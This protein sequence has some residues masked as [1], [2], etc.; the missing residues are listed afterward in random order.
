MASTEA[1]SRIDLEVGGMTCASCA[2]RV[3]K[4]LNE[5]AGVS[6]NVNYAT[7]L[8]SVAYDSDQVRLPDLVRAVESAGYR[9]ALPSSAETKADLV[10]PLRN[11]L[12]VSLALTG[13]LLV[14]SMASPLQFRGWEWLAFALA[15]PIVLWAG[16]PFHRAAVMN[17][18]HLTATMDTLVS[19]GTLAAWGWSV[20][21]LTA[22]LN[23]DVYFEVAGVITTLIL[24][25]RFLEAEARRRSGAAIRAL[26]ELGAKE[27]RVLRDGSEVL[28]PVDELQVGRASCRERVRLLCRSRWSPYH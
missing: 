19:L 6:A 16:L 3:E 7:E 23:A 5:L 10:R 17:A 28:V 9:A 12:L 27:A 22:G 20:V 21:V 18:R 25:G 26:L 14:L 15:T 4:K 13:P 11:R 24:L 1:S 8:A 2:A